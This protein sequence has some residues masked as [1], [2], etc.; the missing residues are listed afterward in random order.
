VSR[1]AIVT[2]AGRGI[3]AA[4]VAG[5]AADGWKVLAVDRGGDDPRLP[6]AMAS[7]AELKAVVTSANQEAAGGEVARATVADAT[8]E[9]AMAAAVAEAE[10]WGELEAIVAAAGVIAGG[11]PAWELP[12]DQQQAVI[13][14]CLGGVIVAARV[15]IPS[16]LRRPQPRSGRFV[17]IASAATFRGL[18]GLA[19]YCA[20]KAGVAGFVRAL[21]TDLRAT[22]ITANAIAPGSTDTPILTESARLYGLDSPQDFAAQQPI[23]RLLEP[24][25]PAA[26]IRWLL[27]PEASAVTGATLP[28]D[29]GLSV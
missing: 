26:L 20:A 15:A 9:A 13:D 1:V 28:V 8:D 19:A 7:E 12:V 6:Y 29:G 2:G 22:G 25:E 4:T 23:E 17:A 14:V 21:A 5:L 16:L 11:A 24:A 3:G 27:T 10:V 18:P